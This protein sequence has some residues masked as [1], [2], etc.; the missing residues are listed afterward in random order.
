MEPEFTKIS[1]NLPDL[2]SDAS[3]NYRQE[4]QQTNFT[5]TALRPSLHSQ[6]RVVCI[7]VS[8]R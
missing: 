3:T 8:T 7:A 5:A 4:I 6:R 2:L 1:Q